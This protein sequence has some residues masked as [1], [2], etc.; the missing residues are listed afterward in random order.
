MVGIGMV[1]ISQGQSHLTE[2]LGAGGEVAPSGE[3]IVAVRPIS[4]TPRVFPSPVIITPIEASS[5]GL[6]VVIATVTLSA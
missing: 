3:T 6:L 4:A 1:R 2:R 5:T